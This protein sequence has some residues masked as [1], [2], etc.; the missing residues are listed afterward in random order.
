MGEMV[1]RLTWLN[2]ATGAANRRV[3]GEDERREPLRGRT[4]G[5]RTGRR[6]SQ[7]RNGRMSVLRAM[8]TTGR[9]NRWTAVLAPKLPV[10][11]QGDG[12]LLRLAVGWSRSLG[13]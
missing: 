13:V 10:E 3:E 12:R 1:K 6:N 11:V 2:R 8:G 4:E 5:L 9:P 7:G